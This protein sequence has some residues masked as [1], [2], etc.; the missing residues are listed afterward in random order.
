LPL[1]LFSDARSGLIGELNPEASNVIRQFGLQPLPH[2]G[3][4]FRRIWESSTRMPGGRPA[5]SAALFL[6]T[7]RDF[8]AW[9]RL[10]AEELWHFY[11]GDPV[12]HVTLDSRG[13]AVVTLLGAAP[14]EGVRPCSAVAANTW[15]AARLRPEMLD[16][17]WALVGCT[18]TPAWEP[19]GMTIGARAEMLREFPRESAWIQALTR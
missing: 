16:C 14:A 15:Q 9:H 12:E 17:S 19:A 4:F 7:P 1:H 2:E 10:D 18:V 5:S 8:S 13:A 11:G 6:M 3:G